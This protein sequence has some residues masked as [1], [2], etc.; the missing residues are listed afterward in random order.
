MTNKEL[1]TKIGELEKIPKTTSSHQGRGL[2][3]EKHI[4]DYLNTEEIL[5]SNP[6]H[7]KDNRSE[8]IDGA[9]KVSDR[10]FLLEIKWV[11]SGIAASDLYSFIGKIDNKFYGTL[12]LFISKNELSNNV[13]KAVSKGRQRK[14]II[15]HG[16]DI[17]DLLEKKIPFKEY[18]DEAVKAYSTNNIDNYSITDYL[19]KIKLNKKIQNNVKTISNSI[20]QYLG[21]ILNS[22]SVD[23]P[24]IF[25]ETSKLNIEQR[26]L[27][28]KYYLENI[29]LY[30]QKFSDFFARSY[31]Y[32]NIL[33]SLKYL[34]INDDL[35]MIHEYWD[36]VV[37]KK[38]FSLVKGE[39]WEMFFDRIDK[40]T[41]DKELIY[42][43]LIAI[44]KESLGI[45]D[46]ENL[47]TEYF[48][49]IWEDLNNVQKIELSKI[50]F[51]IFIST[52][53]ND[54]Y[55]QKA[56][57]RR[58]VKTDFDEI[59][60]KAF[61]KWIKDEIEK[62]IKDLEDEEIDRSM[63]KRVSSYFYRQY[64]DFYKLSSETENDFRDNI[65]KQ[66][67]DLVSKR[68]QIKED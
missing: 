64:K 56:F 61:S 26:K 16:D 51:D 46:N 19:K 59:T 21:I 36:Y 5:I 6:Y 52:N 42:N 32:S 33:N 53:R 68:Y 66:Y 13:L 67:S 58:L 2:E 48:I 34:N 14:V 41:I 39:L 49:T 29:D 27:V 25:S 45:W 54:K 62:D 40:S 24:I 23:D 55:P 7:T 38:Q 43:S 12:G 63:I 65:M 60:K 18:I 44:F 1:I 22:N 20:N 28:F 17:I 35:E 10:I 8:Q 37:K 47:L 4:I 31:T 11:D 15:L 30:Y 57:A 9:I 3:F 50:Y